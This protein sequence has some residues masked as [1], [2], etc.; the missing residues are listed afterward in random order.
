MR[1]A[2]LPTARVELAAAHAL[3]APLV[4]CREALAREY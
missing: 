1:Y 3:R 2:D 4:E